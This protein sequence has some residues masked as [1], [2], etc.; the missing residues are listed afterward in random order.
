MADKL[1]TGRGSGV[2]ALEH[3]PA[4]LQRDEEWAVKDR[5]RSELINKKYTAG[6]D[7][8]EQQ[9][10]DQLQA[11]LEQRLDEIAPVSFEVVEAMEEVIRA[12]KAGENE[13]QREPQKP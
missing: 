10:L 3:P 6:L 5:R 9:A 7:L 12:I 11:E 8:D 1:A 13:E 4:E 2:E